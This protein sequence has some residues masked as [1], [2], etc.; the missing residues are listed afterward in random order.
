MRTFLLYTPRKA[1]HTQSTQ[2]STLLLRAYLASCFTEKTEAQ[3]PPAFSAQP[4]LLHCEHANSPSLCRLAASPLSPRGHGPS[5]CP[6]SLAHQF[7]PFCL[8]GH[9]HQLTKPCGHII[10]LHP[11]TH[12]FIL[13]LTCIPGFPLYFCSPFWQNSAQ[14]VYICCPHPILC[15]IIN[16]SVFKSKGKCLSLPP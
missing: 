5:K 14:M 16:Y 8:P 10:Y 2:H 11:D 1:P 6:L 7:L 4:S 13:I 9:S 3:T 12:T 15:K